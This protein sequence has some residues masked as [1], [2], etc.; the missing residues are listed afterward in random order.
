MVM[1][2]AKNGN[3]F[4]YFKR[5]KSLSEDEAFIY[6]FQTCLGIDFIHKMDIIHRDLKPENI[7]LDSKGNV[8]ISDFG[9]SSLKNN[10]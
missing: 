1:E 7:L 4:Q 10:G 3:L 2:Y 5:R 6:F 8:K 9:W